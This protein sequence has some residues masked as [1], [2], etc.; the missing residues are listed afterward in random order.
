ML[1]SLCAESN[2]RTR[3]S[4]LAFAVTSVPTGLYIV[5]KDGIEAIPN[6]LLTA[7]VV[8][9]VV[10]GT[11]YFYKCGFSLTGCAAQSVGGVACSAIDMLTFK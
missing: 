8:G 7:A 1:S 9:G 10:A 2:R 3:E 6:A 4:L 5:S 11:F